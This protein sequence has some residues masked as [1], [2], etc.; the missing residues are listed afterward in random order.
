MLFFG[1]IDADNDAAQWTKGFT[2]R[3]TDYGRRASPSDI[4]TNISSLRELKALLKPL[5]PE[6]EI[7]ARAVK[8]DTGRKD[9][10]GKAV[11][12]EFPV[13]FDI[14]RRAQKA[15]AVKEN[16]AKADKEKVSDK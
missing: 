6:A 16:A 1:W 8:V 12:G 9:A 7:T 10:K 11:T 3:I 15:K 5:K 2:V 14:A 4:M 13:M